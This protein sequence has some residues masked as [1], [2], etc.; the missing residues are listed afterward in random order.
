M[1]ETALAETGGKISGLTGAASRLG[2]PRQTLESRIRSLGID[3]L[4]FKRQPDEASGWNRP[5]K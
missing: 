1:I 2:L 3:K 5:T 4:R